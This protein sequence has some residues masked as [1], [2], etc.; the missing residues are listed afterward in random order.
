MKNPAG[1]ICEGLK[2]RDG[3]LQRVAGVD[4]AVEAGLRS[5]LQVLAE[6]GGLPSFYPRILL[7]RTSLLPWQTVIIKPSLAQSGD[8]GMPRHFAQGRPNIF[9]RL[10]CIGGMPSHHGV[11]LRI[12]FR[13]LDAAPAA[14]QVRPNANDPS[15]ASRLGAREELRQFG[16]IILIRQVGVGVVKIGCHAND[17]EGKLP[18]AGTDRNAAKAD[19]AWG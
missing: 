13:Q 1:A 3:I 14:F 18:Q 19:G 9:R 5:N 11:K 17:R 12:G 2:L 16:R 15:D 7:R 6:E 8:F 4:Y 10:H